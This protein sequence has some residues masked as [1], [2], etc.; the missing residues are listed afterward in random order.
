MHAKNRDSMSLERKEEPTRKMLDQLPK[1]H[2][3]SLQSIKSNSGA[4]NLSFRE[5]CS[6]EILVRTS[7]KNESRKIIVCSERN[8]TQLKSCSSERISDEEQPS[9]RHLSMRSSQG[10]FNNLINVATLSHKEQDDG[11]TSK[12]SEGK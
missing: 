2:T 7:N 8:P 6:K 9:D 11:N 4:D 1:R 5:V 12:G 10:Q 3:S